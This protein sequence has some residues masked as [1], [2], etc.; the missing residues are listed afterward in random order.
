[1][2][3]SQVYYESS[4]ESTRQIQPRHSGTLHSRSHTTVLTAII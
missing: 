4:S 3:L 1:M 2:P